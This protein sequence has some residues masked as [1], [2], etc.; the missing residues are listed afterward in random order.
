MREELGEDI[1]EEEKKEVEMQTVDDWEE[2]EEDEEDEDYNSE[3]DYSDSE[4]DFEVVNKSSDTPLPTKGFKEKVMKWFKR[5]RDVIFWFTF[6]GVLAII[7]R[8]RRL[9]R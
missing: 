2:E 4:S 3:V 6:F 8:R 5:R 9:K 1:G 7:K